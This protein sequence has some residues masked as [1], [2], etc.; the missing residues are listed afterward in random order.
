[1]KTK[2]KKYLKVWWMLS[3]NSFMSMFSN[4]LGSVVFLLGKIIRFLSFVFFLFFL[5]KGTGSL[6]GYSLNQ[7]MFFFLSFNLVDIISQFLFREVYRFRQQ[8][9]EGTF[10]LVLSKPIN[11]LF[12]S[13]LGGTDVLDLITLPPLLAAIF[14]VAKS[15]NPTFL[16]VV[17]FVFLIF[18]SLIIAASFHI[19]VLALGIVTLEID[20]TI[21]IYRDVTNLGKFPVDIYKEPLRSV[22]TFLIPVGTMMTLPAKSLMGL[23]SFWG[24]VLSFLIGFVFLFLSIKFWNFALTKYSSASN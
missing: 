19:F 11:P 24:V 12:R 15:L 5:I 18:N 10:D 7:T 17:L 22:L 8:I 3:K 21:L 13:L 1:M 2:I 6:A 16:S 23:V 9:V 14:W 4:R 20:H